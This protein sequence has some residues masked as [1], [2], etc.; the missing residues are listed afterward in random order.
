M[1]AVKGASSNRFPYSIIIVQV[2]FITRAYGMQPPWYSYSGTHMHAHGCE[3]SLLTSGTVHDLAVKEQRVTEIPC[4]GSAG[5]EMLATHGLEAMYEY[6]KCA[7][8]WSEL[9]FPQ[10]STGVSRSNS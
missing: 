8:K 3:L 4:L 5:V 2:D 1:G 9:S 7:E 6:T 10:R